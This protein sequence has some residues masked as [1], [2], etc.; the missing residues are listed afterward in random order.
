MLS[1]SEV[2]SNCSGVR[3]LR[4]PMVGPCMEANR[5]RGIVFD[6]SRIHV[7]SLYVSTQ[8]KAGVVDGPQTKIVTELINCMLPGS[9]IAK[10]E[11][12]AT[13]L[14]AKVKGSLG[15][16]AVASY[17][18]TG[19]T[20]NVMNQVSDVLLEAAFPSERCSPGS[21][22]AKHR[23]ACTHLWNSFKVFLADCAKRF[24]YPADCTPDQKKA[25]WEE[26]AVEVEASG[27]V[28]VD[29]LKVVHPK[30]HSLYA[31]FA[32][33]HCGDQFRRHGY[34]P[35]YGMDGIEAK[36]SVTKLLQRQVTNS[37]L[38]QR[39]HTILSHHVLRDVAAEKAMVRVLFFMV[40]VF[41]CEAYMQL[42]RI[43]S[44]RT[45]S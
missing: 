26:R 29:A 21:S 22:M 2:A 3:V 17:N 12:V 31:H 6:V 45:D 18:G 5:R 35:G 7:G 40:D 8:K 34:W 44:R 25:M 23:D 27:R 14:D 20:C 38:Y 42:A 39:L 15:G 41:D 43:L 11:K 33:A 10:L 1:S 36:H 37:L 28:F 30:S 4:A 24:T 13:L 32:S 16:L 19:P 9:K